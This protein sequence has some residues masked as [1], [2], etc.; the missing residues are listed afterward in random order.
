MHQ[1]VIKRFQ[2]PDSIKKFFATTSTPDLG[3][4]III[5]NKMYENQN[6]LYIVPLM[7]HT[8]LVCINSISPMAIGCFICMNIGLGIVLADVI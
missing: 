3:P 2:H 5:M 8:S 6:L 1:L 4:P 7:R